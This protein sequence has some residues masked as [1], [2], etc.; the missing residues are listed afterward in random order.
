MKCL[1]CSKEFDGSKR[2]SEFWKKQHA[3]MGCCADICDECWKSEHN[4]DVRNK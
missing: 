1:E 2:T 3:A 4:I